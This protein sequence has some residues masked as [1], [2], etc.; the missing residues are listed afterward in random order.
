MAQIYH[1]DDHD[2]VV[3]K[4]AELV[5]K[6]NPGKFLVI[7]ALSEGKPVEVGGVRPDIILRSPDGKKTLLVI[8]VET[9]DTINETQAAERWKPISTAAPAFQLVIPKG[10]LPRAKRFCR[11]LDIK[12]RFQ[13]F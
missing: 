4:F 13:E 7:T 5:E 9:A 3:R 8:E 2:T 6:N 12:A 11:R 1:T 10:N